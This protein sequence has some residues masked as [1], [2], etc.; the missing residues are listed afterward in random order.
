MTGL[1]L[2]YNLKV[3]ILIAVFYVFWR[4][5]LAHETWHRLNRVILLLT[6]VFSFVLPLCVVTIHQTVEV[7]AQ[8]VEDYVEMPMPTMAGNP[9]PIPESP[10]IED[11]GMSVNGQLLLIMLYVIG[12]LVVLCRMLVSVWRLY[13]IKSQSELHEVS[14]KVQIAVCDEAE[15]PFSWWSTIYLN[16]KDYEQGVT[17]LLTHELEHVRLH[18]SADVL[19]VEM[20]TALQWF[21]PTMWMLR[22]DLRTIHEY[23]A[24]QQVLSHGFNDI[25]YL[26][27]LIRKSASQGWYSL[28]NGIANSTLKKRITMMM[29][30]ISSRWKWLRIAYVLPVIAVSLYASCKTETEYK[31]KE[32]SAVLLIEREGKPYYS[33][34]APAGS[35]YSWL[36]SGKLVER[37]IVEEDGQWNVRTNLSIEDYI[38]TLDGKQIDKDD[39][40]YI[41]LSSIKELKSLQ[42]DYPRRIELFTT[43]V[44]G[45]SRDQVTQWPK[46]Y[47]DCVKS[48]MFF[49]VEDAATGQQLDGAE[50]SIEG[51]EQKALTNHEGWCELKVPLG[52]TVKVTY[53][54]M[55]PQTMKIDYMNGG[56]IQGRTFWLSKQGDP[57]YFVD[58]LS[59]E[60]EPKFNGDKEQWLA[61]HVQLPKSVKGGGRVSVFAVINE[62]GSVSGVRLMQGVRKELN[63]EAVRVVSAM[64]RWQPA[65][66]D[67]KPV[68]CL[69]F[70]G[71]QFK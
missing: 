7:D 12:V 18:H 57:I 41:P 67:S 40:P 14:G 53:K 64:P 62:D 52:S 23:E 16:H 13:R 21:N 30:P 29:K 26:H 32:E 55:A 10:V 24:D 44:S 63:E 48:W 65:T 1:F 66:K 15:T 38:V 59:K 37:G 31:V 9:R 34:K 43:N 51:T 2:A 70:I 71:V 6:A 25:Q 68:K 46:E 49:R 36:V 33:I 3:A 22:S 50:V 35:F 39:V 54:G 4:L 20:L 47:K 45:F 61:D 58:K 8:S 42:G 5:L 11:V 28:A 19:L 60:Q 56:K 17:A 69:T 27:L